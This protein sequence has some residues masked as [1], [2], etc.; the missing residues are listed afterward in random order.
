MFDLKSRVSIWFHIVGNFYML[1]IDQS[2]DLLM[3]VVCICLY[4][5]LD[6]VVIVLY[7]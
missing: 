3:F 1:V 5:C 2:F 4:V 7:V 6:D